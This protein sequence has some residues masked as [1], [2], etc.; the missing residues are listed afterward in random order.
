MNA[1]NH[2]ATMPR[3]QPRSWLGRPRVYSVTQHNVCGV[4]CINIQSICSRRSGHMFPSKLPLLTRIVTNTQT[5]TYT[6]RLHHSV[7]S[8]RPHLCFARDAASKVDW[9]TGRVL[10]AVK[11][12]TSSTNT[13]THTRVTALCPGLPGWA[14][15]RKENQSGFYWSKRQWVV[16]ASAGPYASAHLAPVRYNHAGNPPLK[17]FL[18][19]GCPSCRPTNS[20]KALK[21]INYFYAF[22]SNIGGSRIF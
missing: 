7:Y 18:Q 11:Y 20:V 21:A 22:R 5:D 1:A 10:K 9:S 17:F 12:S 14:G 6:N 2:C 19:S 13:H 3:S 15:A 4:T 16:V 8:N